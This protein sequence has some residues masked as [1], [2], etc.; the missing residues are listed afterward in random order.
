MAEHRESDRG[1][2]HRWVGRL[3]RV[4]GVASLVGLLLV[5]ALLS[6]IAY[7]LTHL[8]IGDPG[9]GKDSA[10][11]PVT[12]TPRADLRPDQTIRVRSS[13][14]PRDTIVGVAVCLKE[15]DSDH[16]GVDA[17]DLDSGSRF[18]IGGDSHLDA[19]FSVPRV[20]SVGGRPYDCASRPGRCVVVAADANDFDRS[21]GQ[22]ISFARGLPPAPVV[23]SSARPMSDRLP[24]A[25]APAGPLGADSKVTL[26]ARGFEPGEPILVAWCTDDAETEGLA[27]ACSPEDPSA[28]LSAIMGRQISP[29]TVRHADAHGTVVAEVRT[30]AEIGNVWGDVIR[31]DPDDQ[32]TTT[33][34]DCRAKADRCWFVI[35]A[36]ADTKRS[37]ILPYE[38]APA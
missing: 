36:A 31:Q 12:V 25:A 38:V 6:V 2:R 21:G 15:A 35:A 32:T 30:R 27:K 14:F 5:V 22:S 23:E 13:A 34:V 24:I 18:A 29:D 4:V 26:I 9:K 28:A 33:P 8:T 20:I 1:H 17:C 7:A 10:H 16:R 3:L 19:P 37:A 11:L